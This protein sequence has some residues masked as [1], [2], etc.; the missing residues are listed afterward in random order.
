M[1]ETYISYFY[2]FFIFLL[3]SHIFTSIFLLIYS[4]KGHYWTR[5]LYYIK[6]IYFMRA[7]K[8]SASQKF[9]RGLLQCATVKYKTSLHKLQIKTKCF[10]NHKFSLPPQVNIL[11][12]AFTN[13]MRAILFYSVTKVNLPNVYKPL[14]MFCSFFK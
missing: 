3:I 4:K 11:F 13:T 6:Y 5:H 14:Y 9:I 2:I 1:Q 12:V 10:G 8:I 7:I